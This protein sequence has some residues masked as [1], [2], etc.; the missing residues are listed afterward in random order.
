[1]STTSS[2]PLGASTVP[3]AVATPLAAAGAAGGT[4]VPDAEAGLFALLMAALT[5]S[6]AASAPTG[7]MPT[8]T[9]LP[10]AAEGSADA[11]ADDAGTTGDPA[12]AAVATPV[13]LS[14]L[15]FSVLHLVPGLAATLPAATATVPA[16]ATDSVTAPVGTDAAA[17]AATGFAA[18]TDAPADAGTDAATAAPATGTGTDPTATAP[19]TDPGT[20]VPDAAT[21][22]AAPDAPDTTAAAPTDQAS[23]PDPSRSPSDASGQPGQGDD[24]SGQSGQSG[25][26]GRAG[27]QG[28]GQPVAPAPAGVIVP[29]ALLGAAGVAGAGSPLASVLPTAPAGHAPARVSPAEVGS[30]LTSLV[31][32]GEGVHRVTLDLAPAALGDVRVVL[33]VRQGEVHV[34]LAAGD[35]ARAALARSGGELTRALEQV[36]IRD[37]RIVLTDLSSPTG[38]DPFGRS[39][40][41]SDPQQQLLGGHDPQQ[42]PSARH[43]RTDEHGAAT[44]GTPTTTAGS[45]WSSRHPSVVPDSPP[46]AVDLR[47]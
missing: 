31:R 46:G 10:D 18:A 44:E 16:T 32:R 25:Q 12:G 45:T 19:A 4:G 7:S 3:G 30:H 36:G 35:E 17:P 47:M 2:A 14:E 1:M 5:G 15:V 23:A 37:A 21:A 22:A 41:P 38:G 6:T 24:R 27:Q 28:Q 40:D 33:T 39:H 42:R 8:G 20:P 26:D 13:G 9:G 34:R 11:D 29:T 43:P